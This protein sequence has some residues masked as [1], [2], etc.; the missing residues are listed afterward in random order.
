MNFHWDSQVSLAM[1]TCTRKFDTHPLIIGILKVCL[2]KIFHFKFHILEGNVLVI[3]VQDKILVEINLWKC[4]TQALPKIIP[5]LKSLTMSK[6]SETKKVL[7]LANFKKFKSSTINC[8]HDNLARSLVR[9]IQPI[10]LGSCS[11][12][13][14]KKSNKKLNSFLRKRIMKRIFNY[15]GYLKSAMDGLK[16]TNL[17]GP[18]TIAKDRLSKCLEENS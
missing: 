2:F 8:N 9:I 13:H 18:L 3:G 11:N 7:V 16:S 15:I 17:S 10:K 14:S 1:A 6:F 5:K 12:Y 4:F